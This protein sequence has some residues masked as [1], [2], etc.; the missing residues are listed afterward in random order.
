MCSGWG[1]VEADSAGKVGVAA[2]GVAVGAKDGVGSAVGSG[3]GSGSVVGA[4]CVAGAIPHV[5]SMPT[6]SRYRRSIMA[7]GFLNPQQA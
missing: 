6:S 3:V 4:L 7:G 2:D 1:M 5:P